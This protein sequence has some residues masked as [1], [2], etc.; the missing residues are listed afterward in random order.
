MNALHG[1]HTHTHTHKLEQRG[2]G[3]EN[4]EVVNTGVEN[5]GVGSKRLGLRQAANNAPVCKDSC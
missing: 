2:E 3:A 1:M 5:T 4:A